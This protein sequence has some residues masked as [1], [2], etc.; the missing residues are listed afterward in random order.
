M[1]WRQTSTYHGSQVPECR[2]MNRKHINDHILIHLDRRKSLDNCVCLFVRRPVPQG[3][4]H[5]RECDVTMVRGTA[6]RQ[7]V[8]G[9]RTK[10]RL[11]S[12]LFPRNP[13]LPTNQVNGRDPTSIRVSVQSK[14]HVTEGAFRSRKHSV[15]VYK[16]RLDVFQSD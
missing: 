16:I 5:V 6:P 14:D 1:S 15:G 2:E 13:V 3:Y 12:Y 8:P 4:C 11:P 10:P 7:F 9:D